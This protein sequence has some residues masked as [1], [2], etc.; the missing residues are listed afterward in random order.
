MRKSLIL[1]SLIF[2]LPLTT[3][4]E[5][6]F[7]VTRHGNLDAKTLATLN[8]EILAEMTV[9]TAGELE[10]L[11]GQVEQD[12]LRSYTLRLEAFGHRATGTDSGY[13]AR[14]WIASKFT[15]FGYESV[16]IVPF[17]SYR[18]EFL[19]EIPCESYNV[20]A[21]KEGSV[22]PDWKIV[23]CGHFDT[24]INS[25]G[26]D[27][28]ASGTAAV[29]EMARILSDVP[30]EMTIV[31][32]AFDANE[33]DLLG[34]YNFVE[35]VIEQGDDIVLVVNADKIASLGNDARANLYTGPEPA[36]ALIWDYLANTY[37]G[38]EADLFCDGGSDH[39]PFV[40]AGFDAIYVQEG[41]DS[42]PFPDNSTG[43]D[44]DYMTR[45]VQATLATVYF[46]DE[47][48][49]PV[50]VA[51]CRQVGDGESILVNWEA[52]LNQNIDE[53]RVGAF[54]VDNINQV[55]WVSV[56]PTDTNCIV[57]GLIED[58]QYG[59]CVRVVDEDSRVSVPYY[60]CQY[61][62][63]SSIPFAPFSILA[64]PLHE[65][66][67]ITWKSDNT[68]LDFDHLA[69]IRDGAIA[70]ETLDSMY[71]DSD[72]SIG[73][74]MHSYYVTAVDNDGNHSD[75]LGSDPFLMRAATLEPDRI[76]ALN[77]TVISTI[78]F[79]DEA[80]TGAFM[81]E[82]LS[83]YD[84]GYRS[85]TVATTCRWD[86]DEPVHLID[87]IDYGIIVIASEE[88][89]YD[90]LAV[91]P[92]YNGIL[93]TLAYYMSIG[94]K[95]V[96]FGRWGDVGACDTIDYTLNSVSWD[97]A[98]HDYF[99]I[100]FRVQTTTDWPA[101]STVITSD[102][103]GARSEDANYP[104]LVWDSLVTLAHANANS[105][106]ITEVAG[107]PCA[108]FAELG[109]ATPEVIYSYDSR[110]D[111]IF[112]EGQPVAWRY[113]GSDY[114]YIW[115]EI[116]LSMFERSSAI[117]A[118]TQAVDELMD[119]STHAEQGP[120]GESL[121]NTFGLSQNYPNPFNPATEICYSLPSKSKV[122]LSIFNILGQKVTTLVNEDQ[123][124]GS[125]TVQ[126]EG[127]DDGGKSVATGIYLYRLTAGEL[128]ES[129]KMLLLK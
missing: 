55:R 82:A 84:C 129:K 104:N 118:L 85:D 121:P 123:V 44:F 39:Q 5:E 78:D 58:K 97:D 1:V 95:V 42:E 17:D 16:V 41:Y 110:T 122:N 40:E 54:P 73:G 62:I 127:T 13:A 106:T 57:T 66:V 76:L 119:V 72:P 70:G 91:A 26:A 50:R 77:R 45:M 67:K 98:Y 120:S 10:D 79:V 65:A 87:L 35:D 51:S 31:F 56:S 3:A 117:A 71:V 22:Y 90:G 86:C 28:N 80:E 14:D 115:F 15:E 11:I 53:Y 29:L 4:A 49:R 124:A 89:R 27:N 33:S 112:S 69:V 9:L 83:G 7:R 34:S 100:D 88:G 8:P 99:H 32:I 30:S 20:M 103:I 108:S 114:S 36:Y 63:P 59:F 64:V 113:F 107:I 96:I 37:C 75:T 61:I 126:W 60:D 92:I 68:E 46:V 101:F 125:H 47:Y 48:P 128:T 93:D 2:L 38:I 18:R 116:P 25:P 105:A 24:F 94:G 111:N 21:V 109:S 74:D 6:S 23:V 12:S 19:T 52:P 43:L 81:R 102:L